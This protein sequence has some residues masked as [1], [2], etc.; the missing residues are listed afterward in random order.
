[1]L[2]DL[3]L[4]QIIKEWGPLSPNFDS[5]VK[6]PDYINQIFPFL[7]RK[8]IIVLKG[9]RRSG[10]STIMR[11]LVKELIKNK[12]NKKQILYLNLDDFR[13][14]NILNINLL[15][16]VLNVFIN[17]SNNKNKTYFFIDEIQEIEG[18]ESFV[19]TIYDLN[20][21]VK[22]II[23]G[24]NASLLSKEL[25]TLLTGRNITFQIRPLSFKEF[26]K[27]N[28]KGK[29]EEYVTYG[30]FPEV[31]LEKDVF[32]KRILLQQ[33]FED[34]I[35]KDIISR[36]NLRNTELIFNL[37]KGLIENVA[38]KVSL[39]KLSKQLGVSD[40][41]INTYLS[42]LLDAYLI[43]K[44]PYFSYSIKKRHSVLTQPKYYVADNG[45]LYLLKTNYTKDLGK[46]YE[47][48]VLVKLYSLSTEISYWSSKGE[49]DFIYENNAFNVTIA[50]KVPEREYQG[51]K[52]FKHKYNK[53]NLYLICPGPK[54][55]EIKEIK[56]NDFL[57]RFPVY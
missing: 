1:M 44:V 24:S 50:K 19:K 29:L 34:I 32:K 14:K 43:I 7:E 23:S 57:K 41:T 27:F 39:N 53:F 12:V 30:G 45:F 26:C 20:K 55:K 56:F 31:V 11:Q 2:S 4:Y 51:L 35:N 3:E 9:I 28:K 13:L 48:I 25:S 10:K 38:G 37:A 8:E 16:K 22:F 5:G 15:Q 52:E 6:R 21:N 54:E 46:V 18:W 40:D 49:V 33:Y 17:Y 36:Q 42:Y 47:N